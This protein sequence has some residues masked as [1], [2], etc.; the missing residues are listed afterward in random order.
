MNTESIIRLVMLALA[1]FTASPGVLAQGPLTP[2]GAPAPT[3]KTLDQLEPRTPISSLPFTIN[4]PGSYYVTGNLTGPAG[5]HGITVDADNV[6]LDLGGFEL[7]GPG[8]GTFSAVRVNTFRANATVRHGSARGWL[9]SAIAAVSVNSTEFRVE[10]V[11]VFNAGGTGIVLGNN[12]EASHCAARGCVFGGI[13]GGNN[14]HVTACIA[15]GTTTGRG[16]T[17]GT[18]GVI[19]DCTASSNSS[20]GIQTGESSTVS[21]CTAANNSAA[22]FN[23]ASE[24]T[25]RGCTAR[26]NTTNGFVGAN[27]IRLSDCSAAFS[28]SHGFSFAVAASLH[29]CTS[30]F[31][32]INGFQLSDGATVHNCTAQ[33]NNDSGISIAKAGTVTGCT[34]NGNFGT[35]GIA[36]ENGCTV[37]NCTVNNNTSSAVLSAGIVTGPQCHVS[38]CVV[39]GTKSTAATLTSTTGI[40]IAASGGS[41]VESCSVQDSK[42]DGIRA[43]GACLIIGNLCATSGSGTG[44]GAGIHTQNADGRVEGNAVTG[45]D[46]GIHIEGAGNI[47]VKNSATGNTTDYVIA[48]SNRYGAIINISAAGAAA[49][50]GNSAASTLTSTDPWANYSY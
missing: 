26:F 9:G 6:T 48:L 38:H 3:M 5:Q 33:G 17:V 47:I 35:Y 21:N 30:S 37:S 31:N 11:R 39:S 42:G 16:I 15:I 34:A 49:V 28:G 40:G 44:D 12:G 24:A 18:D 43:L 20:D 13:S 32:G 27:N 4:A 46:R 8:S 14:C 19:A 2:P 25:V 41:I 10:D 45:N 29:G 23:L 36:L 7:V 22:G 50:S 1:S